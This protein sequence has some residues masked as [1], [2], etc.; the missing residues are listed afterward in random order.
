[1][2][3]AQGLALGRRA[4]CNWHEIQNRISATG[5]RT[6]VSWV[7]AK[8]PNQLDYIGVE[9]LSARRAH[10]ALSFDFTEEGPGRI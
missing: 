4:R 10:A 9:L 8:Y 3:S 5:T 6:R 2:S 1:M 7:R